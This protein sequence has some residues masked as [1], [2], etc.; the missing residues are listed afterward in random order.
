[1][2]RQWRR[3][4]IAAL[5]MIVASAGQPGSRP[6]LM[7]AGEGEPHAPARLSET[8]L[9]VP[10]QMNVVDSSQPPVLAAIPAVVRRCHQ[11]SMGVPAARHDD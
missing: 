10:G 7:A 11:D 6:R 4:A 3:A 9:Y 2:N 5:T 8:G 1:M